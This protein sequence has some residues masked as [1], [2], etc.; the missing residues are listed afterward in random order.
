MGDNDYKSAATEADTK[1]CLC[2]PIKCGM[3]TLSVFTILGA[4]FSILGL[5]SSFSLGVICIVLA[6]ICVVLGLW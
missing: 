6:A 3:Q 5:A 4:I 1:C 2:F